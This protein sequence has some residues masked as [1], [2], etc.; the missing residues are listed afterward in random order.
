MSRLV[1]H[2]AT[3]KCSAG[4]APSTL[5]VLPANGADSDERPA[6]T[7][8]DCLPNVNIAPF[9]LCTTQANPGVAAATAAQGAL[10]PIPCEPALSAPWSRGSAIVS[11]QERRALTDD[12][13]CTCAWAGTIEIVD[14]GT[15][16]EAD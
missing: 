4:T 5:T 13:K 10:T 16:V 15:S 11:I 8:M 2:G 7:V 3:L 12:S 6:A 1:V 9:G 14:P